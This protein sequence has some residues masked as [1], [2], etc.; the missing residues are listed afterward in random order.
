MGALATDGGVVWVYFA[1]HGAASPETGERLLLGD[2][3]RPDL[4]TSPEPPYTACAADAVS[5]RVGG[6][7]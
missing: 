7:P 5:L 3:I 6:S 4:A 1:G 2:D